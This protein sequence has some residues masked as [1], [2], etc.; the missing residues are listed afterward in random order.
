MSKDTQIDEVEVITDL[1]FPLLH[2]PFAADCF[3]YRGSK[4]K[5]YPLEQ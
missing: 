5:L 4:M 2:D 1:T 3:G